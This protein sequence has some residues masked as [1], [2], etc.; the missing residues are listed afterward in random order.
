MDNPQT[1]PYLGP[2]LS[3]MSRLA[4]KPD[5]Y[6]EIRDGNIGFSLS[7]RILVRILLIKLYRLIGLK[8]ENELN[9]RL[10]GIRVIRVLPTA[11]GIEVPFKISVTAS[12]K[13]LEIISKQ[14]R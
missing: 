14:F 13:S 5:C 8:S 10:F 3:M 1:E 9:T 2:K 6:G 12:N 11:V 7:T 4:T